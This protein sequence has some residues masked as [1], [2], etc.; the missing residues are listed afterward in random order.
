M[1]NPY[2][3]RNIHFNLFLCDDVEV[4]FILAVRILLPVQAAPPP[5]TRAFIALVATRHPVL[6]LACVPATST[7]HFTTL[8]TALAWRKLQQN[9]GCTPRSRLQDLRVS[10]TALD[11]V[12]GVCSYLSRVPCRH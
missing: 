12:R 5:T 7:D 11:K 1:N 4:E 3:E 6:P 9:S 10:V 2:M 8:T